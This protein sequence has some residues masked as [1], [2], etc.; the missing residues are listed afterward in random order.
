M[1]PATCG[2]AIEVPEIVFIAVL[3]LIHD[4]VMP[5]PGA[6]ISTQ[7]PMLLNEAITVDI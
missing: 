7:L 5:A 2:A 1:A 6:I 4:E 3:L